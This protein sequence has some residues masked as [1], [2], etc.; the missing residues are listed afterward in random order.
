MRSLCLASF[1]QCNGLKVYPCCSMYR[2]FIPFLSFCTDRLRFIYPFINCAFGLLP[3]LAIINNNA[4]SAYVQVYCSYVFLILPQSSIAGS[5]G[6]PVF[7]IL[8]NCQTLCQSG[9]CSAHSQLCVRAPASH[10]LTTTW[11]CPSF[12]LWAGDSCSYLVH[13]LLYWVALVLLA[14]G[15]ERFIYLFI[16]GEVG[17]EGRDDVS[18]E[19]CH[20]TLSKDSILSLRERK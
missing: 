16:C 6:D 14:E 2:K 18:R 9:C 10:T 13:K 12:G 17:G 1:A 4:I 19:S 11:Y 20:P 15:K 8:G 7:N 3:F 5:Y